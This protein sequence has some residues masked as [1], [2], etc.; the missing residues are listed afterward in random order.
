MLLH[1]R[2]QRLQ[3][4]QPRWQQARKLYLPHQEFHSAGLIKPDQPTDC[5]QS[6]WACEHPT[7]SQCAHQVADWVSQHA[8][9]FNIGTRVLEHLAVTYT[10][11][12]RRFAR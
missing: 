2:R 11:W 5:P 10:S 4:T 12:T 7:E 6:L 1:P 8:D 9:L 3:C